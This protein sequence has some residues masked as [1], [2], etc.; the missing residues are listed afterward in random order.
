MNHLL[1]SI[2]K[3]ENKQ[4]ENTFTYFLA[5]PWSDTFFEFIKPF[6][7]VEIVNIDGFI[8]RADL[9]EHKTKTLL[10]TLNINKSHNEINI[11]YYKTKNLRLFIQRVERQVKKYQSCVM[12]GSCSMY[13]KEG[14][15]NINGGFLID[16][17]KCNHCLSC[18]RAPCIAVESL[19]PKGPLSDWRDYNGVN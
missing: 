19:T 15:I 9:V 2:K 16:S 14:A 10:A 17:E 13:C 4:E 5:R 12:C 11:T 3:T 6:G 7:D 8:L 18:V 1:A